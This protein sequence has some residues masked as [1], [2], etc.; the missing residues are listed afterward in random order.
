MLV[1]NTLICQNMYYSIK[2]SIGKET[3][4]VFPQVHCL[5]QLHAH[6]LHSDEFP[7]FEPSLVFELEKKAK[8]TDVLS[9]AAISAQGLLISKKLKTLLEEHNLMRHKFYPSLV[10]TRDGDVVYYWLHLCQSYAEF[11]DYK[12]SVFCWTKFELQQ[13]EID[14]SSIEDYNKKKKEHDINW[15]VDVESIKLTDKFSPNI[16]VFSFMPFDFTLYISD[17]LRNQLLDLR[18]TGLKIENALNIS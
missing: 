14:V 10:K 2:N 4:N 3:G 13:G 8:L 17:R 9:Q 16:D 11:I 1:K 18:I 15:G 7:N 12:Q 5:T 6:Q